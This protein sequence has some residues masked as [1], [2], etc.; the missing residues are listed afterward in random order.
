[1]AWKATDWYTEPKTACNF[2]SCNW[3]QYNNWNRYSQAYDTTDSGDGEN[4]ITYFRTNSAVNS[5]S[6]I[7]RCQVRK[8]NGGTYWLYS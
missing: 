6:M 7:L 4:F 5:Y 8:K 1:M 3:Y 2:Q